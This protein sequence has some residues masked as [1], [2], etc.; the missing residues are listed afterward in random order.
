VPPVIGVWLPL[1][2]AYTFTRVSEES[3]LVTARLAVGTR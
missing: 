1:A 2:W 3:R